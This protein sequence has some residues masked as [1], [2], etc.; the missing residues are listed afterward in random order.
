MTLLL[1]YIM[2]ALIIFFN[3]KEA[4]FK[5]I[6]LILSKNKK[7]INLDIFYTFDSNNFVFI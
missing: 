6:R 4:I 3:F 7:F 2:R 1:Q 5:S